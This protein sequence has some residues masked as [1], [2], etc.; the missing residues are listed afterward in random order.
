MKNNREDLT[1]DK[2]SLKIDINNC[3][4]KLKVEYQNEEEIYILFRKYNVFDIIKFSYIKSIENIDKER[5]IDYQDWN[6]IQVSFLALKH[7]SLYKKTSFKMVDF[8]NLYNANNTHNTMIL[9]KNKS[10][11]NKVNVQKILNYER[12]FINNAGFI[13]QFNR[14][15]HILKFISR[16]EKFINFINS[17]NINYIDCIKLI[18]NLTL[19]NFDMYIDYLFILCL[20]GYHNIDVELEIK[21][22]TNDHILYNYDDFIRILNLLSRNVEFFR[23]TDLDWNILRVNPII[24]TRNEYLV[25]NYIAYCYKLFLSPYWLLRNYYENN[26]S[27]DFISFF[28][29]C[30]ELYLQD[31]FDNYKIEAKKVP[32]VNKKMPDWKIETEKFIF[33]IEQKS[34]LYPLNTYSFT[35]SGNEKSI[36]K[37]ENNF[38]EAFE[39]LNNYNPKTNKT[40][41]RMCLLL[42][43]MEMPEII[44]ERVLPKIKNLKSKHL[45]WLI[46]IDDFEKLFYLYST[47][48]NEF[49]LIIENK[50]K[51]EETQ[52]MNGRNFRKLLINA[53]ND[54][55]ENKIDYFTSICEKNLNSMLKLNSD[56]YE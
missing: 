7:S 52:D 45:N 30:F 36:E 53:K 2:T 24:K 47:N 41:I 48:T 12:D 13:G 37:F 9:H 38:I 33:L 46:N 51:L 39:Q 29:Y 49:N 34:S 54:Y 50:I 4:N 11:D 14:I 44:E 15:Y 3:I 28:G 27:T 55:I 42:E 19:I 35:N 23:N 16:N 17:K 40:I 5:V 22:F 26:N 18:E 56:K 32:E 1:Y 20:F 31:F 43:S 25:I 8:V 21:K 10:E 6:L